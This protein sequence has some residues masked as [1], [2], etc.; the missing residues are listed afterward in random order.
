MSFINTFGTVLSIFMLTIIFVLSNSR[1][2]ENAMNITQEKSEMEKDTLEPVVHVN[3]ILLKTS[4]LSTD[5]STEQMV[6]VD[7]EENIYSTFYNIPHVFVTNRQI[8]E[9]SVGL[10]KLVCVILY[11][12]QQTILGYYSLINAIPLLFYQNGIQSNKDISVCYIPKEIHENPDLFNYFTYITQYYLS[13][14]TNIAS[15]DNH[16]DVYN[17]LYLT[18]TVVELKQETSTYPYLCLHSIQQDLFNRILNYKAVVN[19][20]KILNI[21]VLHEPEGFQWCDEAETT[22]KALKGSPYKWQVTRTSMTPLTVAERVELITHIDVL[23]MPY[24]SFIYYILFLQPY[25]AA[26][27]IMPDN[28][29]DPNLQM[30]YSMSHIVLRQVA[31][32]NTMDMTT[33]TSYINS[34]CTNDWKNLPCHVDDRHLA[35]QVDDAILHVIMSKY[36]EDW[37]HPQTRYPL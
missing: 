37:S 29:Y 13:D 26:I 22:R 14:S 8:S 20:R 15:Y 12:N 10:D 33:C 36:N 23:L 24:N 28:Y 1:N 21:T 11:T 9:K 16:T 27:V 30:L 35:I 4:S 17:R 19:T 3:S 31:T 25:S 2:N 34:K 32:I 5:N 6:Q 18:H 7:V